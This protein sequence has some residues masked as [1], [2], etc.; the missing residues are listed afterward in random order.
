MKTISE[1]RIKHPKRTVDDNV[2]FGMKL[3]LKA[4]LTKNAHMAK[5]NLLMILI[6]IEISLFYI[7]AVM[8]MVELNL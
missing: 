2:I 6:G 5:I 8:K 3:I 7:F 1:G 4:T